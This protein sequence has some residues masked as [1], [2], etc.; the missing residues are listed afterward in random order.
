MSGDFYDVD[1]QLLD[2]LARGELIFDDPTALL[3]QAWAEP[4]LVDAA[5]SWRSFSLE[6]VEER[7]ADVLQEVVGAGWAGPKAGVSGILAAAGLSASTVLLRDAPEHFVDMARFE[8]GAGS[9]QSLNAGPPAGPMRPPGRPP[10]GPRPGP[11]PETAGPSTE[12]VPVPRAE[13]TRYQQ[14][15]HRPAAQDPHTEPVEPVE[16]GRAP[17]NAG[18][19][20]APGNPVVPAPPTAPI[21]MSP[22]GQQKARGPV[23]EQDGGGHTRV[24]PVAGRTVAAPVVAAATARV[25]A[26]DRGYDAEAGSPREEAHTRRMPPA[27]ATASLDRDATGDSGRSP[28]KTQ[29]A[30]AGPPKGVLATLDDRNEEFSASEERPAKG[31][32]GT[33]AVGGGVA[34]CILGS[35]ALAI[36]GVD[37][38]LLS[39]IVRPVKIQNQNNKPSSTIT[40]K[41]TAGATSS[42]SSSSVGNRTSPV[43]VPAHRPS[44][45][46][47]PT[48]ASPKAPTPSRVQPTIRDHPVP[49]PPPAAPPV[50][51]P[52]QQPPPPVAPPPVPPK[53]P[54]QKPPAPKPPPVAPPPAPEAP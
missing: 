49:P 9:R 33:A 42:P 32:V 4:V 52:P 46:G 17:G 1:D 41:S 3:L 36:A 2:A 19:G 25:A 12:D 28:A 21:E 51:P 54:V 35:V 6:A 18:Q 47:R 8:A 53:P 27:A 43:S 7:A 15:G 38:P 29:I 5:G 10:A 40:T 30:A 31:A 11:D 34:L 24:Q 20:D 37:V 45:P 14:G 50:A 44:D 22:A 48:V 13:E 16:A 26:V 39:P 23:P